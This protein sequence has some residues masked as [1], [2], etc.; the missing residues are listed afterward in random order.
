VG[1]LP[2]D[3]QPAQPLQ[4]TIDKTPEGAADRD[5]A[6]GRYDEAARA[7]GEALAASPK[8]GW[9]MLGQVRATMQQGK[10]PEALALANK[11]LEAYPN[12]PLVVTA[13]GEVRYRRGEIGEAA[14]DFNKAQQLNP[15]LGEVHYDVAR[16]LNLSGMFAKAQR[17]LDAAHTLSPNSA[18][19]TRR[20]FQSHAV[21]PTEAQTRERLTR[22]LESPSLSEDEKQGLTAALKGLDSKEKGGCELASPPGPV[23]LQ[24]VPMQEGAGLDQRDMTGAGL[25]ISFNGKKRRLEI[26]T[27][28]SGLLLS[29]SVAKAAGLVPEV[30]VKM[31]GIGDQG[32]SG[33]YVTHV[34]DIRIGSMEFKNCSVRVLERSMQGIDGLIGTDVFRD[35]VV[36]LDT[37][38]RELRLGLLPKRP[39]DEDQ[40]L[41]LD[42]DEDESPKSQAETAK[43]QYIAPE[44]KDWTRI[45]R[46]GHYLIVPTE[47]GNTPT[48]LFML[49]TGAQGSMISPAVARE[50]SHVS[51]NTAM[52]VHGISGQVQKVM[53]AESVSI[54]FAH[55]KQ[56]TRDMLAYESGFMHTGAGVE[57]S[58]LIGF[59]ML[60]ELVL[61][62][63]YRDNLINAVYDPKK[64][65]HAR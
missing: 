61:S 41:S 59:P 5:L 39:G 57:I 62:I 28:A 11:Y 44:M 17:Q 65:F 8:S 23:K 4:C 47:I 42:T 9:L 33:G 34:D 40:H 24:I 37:P 20:W 29:R 32:P 12:D 53:E 14:Q 46:Y 26:D 64:G 51:G 25:E 63:D 52:E 36:T 35:Y 22:R 38:G 21:P 3:A 55:V 60:R 19:I 2:M 54:Q 7:Y 10:V 50:V 16:F 31:G 58:G 45:F 43:D 30:N 13:M 15:C 1:L 56:I 6:S 49:D 18:A 48:K 27:G